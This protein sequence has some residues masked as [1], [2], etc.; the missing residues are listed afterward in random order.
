MTFAKKL[1]LIAVT[2]MCAFGGSGYASAA[3]HV[4]FGVSIGAPFP[5][6]YRPYYY[7]PVYPYP[8]Y[9]P[10]VITVPVQ[11]PTYIEAPQAAAPAPDTSAQNWW[12][13]CDESRTYYPYVK[14]CPAGWQRV[15]PRP[16]S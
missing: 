3:G 14:E 1:L 10:T 15:S 9:P 4:H 6:Y 2:L 11:P 8:Y 13:Y 7:P 5:Y 12:Y 16:Q